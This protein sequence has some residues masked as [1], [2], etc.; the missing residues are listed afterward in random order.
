MNNR[1]PERILRP[2][3]IL[4]QNLLPASE[5]AKYNKNVGVI[6]RGAQWRRGRAHNTIVK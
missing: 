2:S 5:F 3:I 6:H 1:I 4:V